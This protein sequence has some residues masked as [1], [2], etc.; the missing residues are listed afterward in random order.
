MERWW[1]EWVKSKH[2]LRKKAA[3]KAPTSSRS[4]KSPFLFG[5][6]RVGGW[7]RGEFTAGRR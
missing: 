7:V 4:D 2:N 1:V 5:W 3:E 6:G